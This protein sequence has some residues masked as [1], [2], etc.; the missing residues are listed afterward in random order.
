VSANVDNPT[1]PASTLRR[2]AI[3]AVAA[4]IVLTAA[5]FW[6][7]YA[8]LHT[9]A[10]D[11]GL[12]GVRAWAW[13]ATVD[14]FIV[15]GETL[16]L[17]ASLSRR[18]DCAAIGLTV[19]GSGGSIALNVAGVGSGASR[20]TYVVAAVPPVAALFAFGAL[21][22]Q[23]HGA[24]V[25]EQPEPVAEPAEVPGAGAIGP[26]VEPAG[27]NQV[28][29]PPEPQVEPGP[30]LTRT[31]PRRTGST[32]PAKPRRNPPEPEADAGQ[33][34]PS[35]GEQ[36]RQILDLIEEHGYDTVKLKFVQEQ[37]GMPK[38]TAYNRLIEARTAW[39]EEHGDAD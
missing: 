27:V 12:D 23:F 32:P 24:L 1:A 26:I 25:R 35:V 21:M 15:V 14:L 38:T 8:H 3:V 11:N 28:P 9:V 36:V 33:P 17:V 39:A 34:T 29:E 16:L 2:L 4:T 30:N 6:L 20:M 18:V 22:R 31:T 7:S 37:T 19:I 5:A 10:A 13:P